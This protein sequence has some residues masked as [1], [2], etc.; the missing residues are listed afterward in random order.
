MKSVLKI[1]AWLIAFLIVLF[2][3]FRIE[4]LDEHQLKS[5]KTTFDAVKFVQNFWEND[6]P[7][8]IEEATPVSEI[9][10]LFDSNL[11]LAFEK[12]GKKLGI[13]KTRYFMAKGSGIITLVSDEYLLVQLPNSQ[14]IKIAT[15]FIFGNAIREGSGKV[16]INDFVNMTDFN[17]VSVAIN[18]LAKE[19]VVARLKKN[20][21]AGQQIEFAGAFELSE[22][23]TAFENVLLIPVSAKLSDGKSE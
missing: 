17:N 13:S 19:K 23:N 21:V 7:V 12:F 2:F 6:L 20:A 22:E 10:S 18:K 1:S 9:F 3:S 11:E 16:N 8:S 14:E 15:D 4:K 5:A